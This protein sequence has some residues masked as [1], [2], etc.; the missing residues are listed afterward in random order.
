MT[1]RRQA[2]MVHA[3]FAL[4]FLTATFAMLLGVPMLLPKFEGSNGVGLSPSTILCLGACTSWQS[5]SP[6]VAGS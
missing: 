1:A 4:G 2:M 5:P 3:G 6:L